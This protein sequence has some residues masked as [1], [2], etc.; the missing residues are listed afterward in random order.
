MKHVGN[1]E[2]MDFVSVIEVSV[3]G[4]SNEQPAG[5][6]WPS[7]TPVTQVDWQKFTDKCC[8]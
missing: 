4:V 6:I 7:R 8:Q 5:C 2:T 1:A 3:A